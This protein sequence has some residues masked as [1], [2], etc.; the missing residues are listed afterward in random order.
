[1]YW[2]QWTTPG[3]IM[4]AAMDGSN[5]TFFVEN[6]LTWP[7]GLTIDHIAGRLY[8]CDSF[9]DRIE[10]INLDGTNRMVNESAF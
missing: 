6:D 4:R 7:N 2:G 9:T 5:R 3:V 8:W 1:M 10:R